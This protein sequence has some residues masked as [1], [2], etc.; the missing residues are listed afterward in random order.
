MA[1][2][3]PACLYQEK[4]GCK[5]KFGSKINHSLVAVKTELIFFSKSQKI[6]LLKTENGQSQIKENIPAVYLG[7]DWPIQSSQRHVKTT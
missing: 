1:I 5:T 2:I 3:V 6:L 4:S 7:V